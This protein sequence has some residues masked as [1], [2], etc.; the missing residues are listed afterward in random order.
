ML[1]GLDLFS[2]IGG[3]AVGLREYVR[4]VAYCEIET[5]CR[6]VLCSRMS[7]GALENA[8]IWDDVT[9]LDGHQFGDE[10]DIVTAGFPCQDISTA[11]NGAGL[12]GQRS[13]LFFEVLRLVGEI[14]PSFIFLENVPAVTHRGGLRIVGE[15]AALGYD[16]RWSIVS[17]SELGANHKRERWFLLAHTNRDRLRVEQSRCERGAGQVG[18][19]IKFNGEVGN[20]ANTEGEPR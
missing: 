3:I 2:G 20:V 7:N 9:T 13:G 18:H 5:Y 12:E 10:V 6:G 17:A 15:F 19:V 4:P 1:N 11:G 8:P 16:S 14:R